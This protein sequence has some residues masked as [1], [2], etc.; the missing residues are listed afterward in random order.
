MVILPSPRNYNLHSPLLVCLYYI[1]YARVYKHTTR[2]RTVFFNRIQNDT[3]S[4]FNKIWRITVNVEN[5]KD[6][7]SQIIVINHR[8]R[9]GLGFT[10]RALVTSKEGDVKHKNL[11]PAT[12]MEYK[13]TIP[14]IRVA[15][16][17]MTIVTRSSYHHYQLFD[18]HIYT[19]TP[20][21]I[22]HYFIYNAR[23][24]TTYARKS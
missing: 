7:N 11:R 1:Y 9:N 14:I 10:T 15:R 19:D 6:T 16:T 13:T 4:E 12:Y 23:Y 2:I 18:I 22:T 24:T 20:I 8:L 17:I 5:P 3:S 21:C